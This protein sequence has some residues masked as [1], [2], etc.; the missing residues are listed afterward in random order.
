MNTTS[1][2]ISRGLLAG[3]AISC[4]MVLATACA[5]A[6]DTSNS[7]GTTTLPA[8]GGASATAGSSTAAAAATTA[9]PA[10]ATTAAAAGGPAGCATRDLSAKTTNGQG[11]AGS[12]YVNIDFTN[13]SNTTCTVYGYP[14]VSLA[15]GTPVA[16]IG[17]AATR[18]TAASPQLVTLAPGAVGN[19]LLQVVDA[20]NFPPANCSPTNATYLQIYPPN[21][22][23]PMYVAFSSQAC[24][25]PE[26]ILT[27]GVIQP[28]V[29]G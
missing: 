3:G 17:L 23:T 9:P 10:Q 12:I 15:G 11:T 14:G 8:G 22:T 4:L 16:Q 25:K 28:G 13:I 20:G 19:A 29:G 2:T 24:A 18:S 21:Q 26:Q 5:T 7:S 27:I 6:S 1:R